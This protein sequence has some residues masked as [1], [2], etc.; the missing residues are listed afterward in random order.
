MTVTE[1]FK[2]TG[3]TNL[4][5]IDKVLLTKQKLELIRTVNTLRVETNPYKVT[6]SPFAGQES[7]PLS[8]DDVK[9]AYDDAIDYIED[10][11]DKNDQ[12][13]TAS[14]GVKPKP[15]GKGWWETAKDSLG[16]LGAGAMGLL[17]KAG[18]KVAS[19][20]SAIGGSL[21]TAGKTTVNALGNGAKAVGGVLAAGG[22]AIAAG[23]SNA[24]H[25]A[26]DAT[27]A[28]IEATANVFKT[29]PSDLKGDPK[30]NQLL[31]YQA[32]LNAGFSPAQA[33]ALTAEVGREN[34][35]ASKYLYG[36]HGDPA[37]GKIN[38]GFISWQK[39]RRDRLI[40]HMASKDLIQPDGNFKPGI[41][42]L[43][44]MAKFLRWEIEKSGGYKT[45]KREFLDV[46]DIDSERAAWILGKYFVGWRIEDPK[47][48]ASGHGRRRS[49][50]RSLE[51]QLA[52]TPALSSAP[53]IA[54]TT[55]TK[56]SAATPLGITKTP[57]TSTSPLVKASFSPTPSSDKPIMM[58]GVTE[59]PKATPV[60]EVKRTEAAK[61]QNKEME[62]MALLAREQ[63]RMQTRSADT[64]DN[65]FALMQ[66][67]EKQATSKPAN[68]AQP[69]P[70]PEAKP[71]PKSPIDV[72]RTY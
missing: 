24:Y 8:M 6:T 54:S 31:V 21:T 70:N 59:S 11:A 43:T 13:V 69:L 41:E 45:A 39:E 27:S 58:Q 26:V 61:V 16:A 56:P 50:E 20:A 18:Q 33:K 67:M 46:P 4:T 51:Q 17:S 3:K 25:G 35:Y 12:T 19:V 65:I 47:Y 32:F 30:K 52:K 34:D 15:E 64:L 71:T 72:S 68:S 57:E 49:H 53:A 28:A 37:N 1:L 66:R 22:G 38:Q 44:E 60:A 40:S 5:D 63:L 2:H 48:A 29:K 62:G 10:N 36:I 55:P 42:S 9:D 14:S 23:A 7:V